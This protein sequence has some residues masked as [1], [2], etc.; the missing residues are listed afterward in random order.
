MHCPTSCFNFKVYLIYLLKPFPSGA[1]DGT[2][3]ENPAVD[4]SSVCVILVLFLPFFFSLRTA[5]L[6]ILSC[7][8]RVMFGLHLE[9]TGCKEPISKDTASTCEQRPLCLN[10]L[11]SQ[12]GNFPS[13]T[14]TRWRPSPAVDM[15]TLFISLPGA[16][17]TPSSFKITSAFRHE[18]LNISGRPLSLKLP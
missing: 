11:Q 12:T 14:L 7:S 3:S 13:V 15:I 6:G 5:P 16:C 1:T 9:S 4:G 17:P 2:L 8:W 10:P 18:A